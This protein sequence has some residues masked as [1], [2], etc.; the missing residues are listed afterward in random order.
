MKRIPLF[1]LLHDGPSDVHVWRVDI[2]F[3]ATLDDEAFAALSGDERAQARAFR[4]S[5]DALRFATVRV[6]LREQLASVLGIAP[7]ALR[8]VRDAMG[9][10]SVDAAASLDFNVSH[11]GA[12]GLIALSM[13]RRV[14]VDIEQCRADLDWLSLASL[15]LAES[16]VAWLGNAPADGHLVHFYD[17]WV[18]KEA[19]LK[20]SGVGVVRGLRHLTV[21]PRDGVRVSLHDPVPDEARDLAATWLAAPAGYA[22]CVAWSTH[23]G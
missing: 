11:S 17:A 2:D 12:Y 22:A 16:E 9:R 14:G 3:A 6:A 13:Q 18:A 15:T 5:E 19:L 21:L 20:T 1:P 8:L 7:H 23:D 10:P 4:R